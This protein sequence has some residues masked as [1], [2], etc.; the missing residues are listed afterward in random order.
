[1]GTS[2]VARV[3]DRPSTWVS[4]DAVA[5]TVKAVADRLLPSGRLTDLLHGKPI[6]HPAHPPLAQAAL[7]GWS[8][9]A[10]LAAVELCRGDG[11]GRPARDLL[12]WSAAGGALPTVVTGLSDWADLHEDQQR[13]GLVHAA[14]MGTASAL[15]LAGRLARNSRRSAA[16]DLGAGVV[17]TVGGALGGHL[18][19]RWAAGANHAEAFP[20]L[21][22]EGWS[23]VCRLDELADGVPHGVVVGDEPVVVCRSGPDVHAL[24]DRCSHLGGPLREG[25]VREVDGAACLVCPWHRSAF[26]LS[27]GDVVAGPAYVGQPALDVRVNF[28]WVDVRPRPLP[29]VAGR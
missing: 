2:I 21:A 9:A 20:H 5:V 16:L 22:K 8:A 4:L 6:G 3:L 18:A 27:D 14:V 19:Y 1:M 28:G 10:L 17:A 29:G 15:S 13:T 26:R 7:G 25:E 23:R 12:G 11:S 24:A